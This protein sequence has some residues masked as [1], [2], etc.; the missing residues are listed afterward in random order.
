M[1]RRLMRDDPPALGRVSAA[2]SGWALVAAAH[3][4]AIA[5]QKSRKLDAT[6]AVV[7][8]LYAAGYA[9]LCGALAAGA[10]FAWTRLI[11]LPRLAP[12]A[13]RPRLS[14]V[15]AVAIGSGALG[16]VFLD[17]DAA[18]FAGR[19][20]A[21]TGFPY[22]VLL[23]ISSIAGG[24]VVAV[25][26]GA[27]LL[28]RRRW[29]R[30]VACAGALAIGVVNGV[31]LAYSYE[32][33]HLFLAI[34]GATLAGAALVGARLPRV[35][36]RAPSRGPLVAVLVSGALGL[37]AVL[38][39][40]PNKA[41]VELARQPAA[42]LA[43]FPVLPQDDLDFRWQPPPSVEP[44]F[45]RRDALPAVPP[46]G[47]LTLRDPI[48]IM[49]GIDSMRADL[50]ADDAYRS[51]LP[52]LFQLRDEGVYF[53]NARSPG[54]STAPALAAIFS[55]A[56]YSQQYWVRH[57]KRPAEPFPHLDQTPRFP[58]LLAE[59]GVATITTDA[60]GWLLNEF[61]I[62]RGF[63]DE[64]GL[65]EAGGG[66]PR[67][68]ALL[69]PL[70]PRIAGHGRG[71]VFAFSHLLHAHSPYTSVRKDGTSFEN[72]VAELAWVD[73]Q[74]KRLRAELVKKRLWSRTVLV[75]YSDHGEA[76]GEHGLNFHGQ[77]LY[78]ELLRVPLVIRVPGRGASVV[79][80]PV[81]LVDIGPTVLDLFGLEAPPQSMGQSLVPLIAGD[82]VTLDRPIV[83][84]ARLKRALVQRDGTKVIHDSRMRTVEVYDL[85]S[86]P[87]EEQNL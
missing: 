3:A 34:A 75:L 52:T 60:S 73:S 13:S 83:A 31:T 37:A 57:P 32:G 39:H 65:R 77:A 4:G 66:Y 49:I 43:P 29:V 26:F 68:N 87:G 58:E 6:S 80:E 74:I 16:A 48:V 69:E 25:A 28:L 2:L 33:V 64:V 67:A 38:V 71:P 72:Y 81:S 47:R 41:S 62:V 79:D 50:L 14:A 21:A 10:C 23:A 18:G 36:L 55:G 35:V 85:A 24:L 8:E 27:G 86:D 40:P 7:V 61:G 30:L 17:L 51:A 42:F 76:F 63:T 82:E 5:W 46:S 78:E 15:V 45:A 1:I 11:A 22:D 19:A 84:E 70:P 56:Y 53:T 54:T 9:A 44:W 20:A 12:L 59:A